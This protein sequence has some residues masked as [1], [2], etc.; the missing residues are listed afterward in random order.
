[1]S[2]REHDFNLTTPTPCYLRFLEHGPCLRQGEY[3]ENWGKLGKHGGKG[4]GGWV[5][6]GRN[7]VHCEF[8]SL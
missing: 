3:G 5:T 7:M 8:Q 2:M 4:G 1:M 6:R